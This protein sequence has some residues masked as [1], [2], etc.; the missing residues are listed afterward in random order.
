[1]INK[2]KHRRIKKDYQNKKLNNPF[3]RKK[4]KPKKEKKNHKLLYFLILIF[5][6]A[7]FWLIFCAPFWQIKNIKIE[8]LTRFDDS[9]I[10]NI[11]EPSFGEK[12]FIFFSN[13]NLILFQKNK[14]IENILSDHKFSN[15]VIKKKLPNTLKVTIN[16]KPYSFIYC[17][18]DSCNYVSIDHYVL[19]NIDLKN[20]NN[21]QD[22][23]KYYI[24]NNETGD[25]LIKSNNNLNIGED[26]LNFITK[27]D[28][29]TTDFIDDFQVLYYI[30][31]D[32]YFKK[33]LI[34]TTEGPE[35]II[36]VNREVRE[37]LEQFSLVKKEMIKD[38]FKELEYIDLRIS[39]KIYFSP[40]NIININ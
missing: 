30:I 8:G 3:F 24:I 10:I 40:E 16:E 32:N 21:S 33:I 20:E 22:I 28:T 15:V 4:E 17:E 6:V 18:N 2:R 39:N 38:K 29:E 11:I 25:S 35:L 26:Y 9:E 23:E 12:R 19:D 36:N 1:M 5:L 27:L 14:I 13:Q 7:L 37:Q 34:K 31:P